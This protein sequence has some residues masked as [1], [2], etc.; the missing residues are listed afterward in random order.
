[1]V[2]VAALSSD[3]GCQKNSHF[4]PL[5]PKV[6]IGIYIE[7]KNSNLSKLPRNKGFEIQRWEKANL[8]PV[9]L[10][11]TEFNCQHVTD[12]IRPPANTLDHSLAER[13]WRASLVEG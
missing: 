3:E 1:M 7:K 11:S 5:A 9:R 10:A 12:P 8:S 6:G 4:L 13:Q 2:V